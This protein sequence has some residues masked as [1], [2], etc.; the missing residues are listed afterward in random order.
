[1]VHGVS[2]FAA[3]RIGAATGV[4]VGAPIAS[5]A[6]TLNRLCGSGFQAI[7]SGAEQIL[8]GRRA[9]G[10]QDDDGVNGLAPCL[11]GDADDGHLRDGRV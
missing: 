4:R 3:R 5:P 8:L 6:L 1:M 9:A 2:G 10:M 11:V 7:I